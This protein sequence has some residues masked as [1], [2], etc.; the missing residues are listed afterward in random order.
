MNAANRI[1]RI[2][3]SLVLTLTSPHLAAARL[4]RLGRFQFLTLCLPPYFLY[5]GQAHRG[6]QHRAHPLRA[7]HH[8][9]Y[10]SSPHISLPKT[11]PKS[12]SRTGHRSVLPPHQG[13]YQSINKRRSLERQLHLEVGS[14]FEAREAVVEFCELC[15]WTIQSLLGSRHDSQV[16]KIVAALYGYVQQGQLLDGLALAK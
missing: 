3:V 16:V 6:L 4:Q 14:D 15:C 9:L 12:H 10:K 1:R 2:S 7:G 11:H 5:R 8:E 13:A